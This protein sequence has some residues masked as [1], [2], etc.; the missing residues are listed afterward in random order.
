MFSNG[1]CN[2]Y[3][4]HLC[5]IKGVLRVVEI[6]PFACKHL[7]LYSVSQ[8]NPPQKFSYIFFPNGWEFLLQNLHTY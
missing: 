6:L 7:G 1:I 8:K 2:E 3:F 5:L 4:C